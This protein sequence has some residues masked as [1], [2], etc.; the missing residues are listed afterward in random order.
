MKNRLFVFFTAFFFST[1]SLAENV[2]IEAKN[3]TLDKDQEISIFENDVT[4][5]TKDKIIKS[6][7]VRYNKKKGILIIKENI[8]VRDNQ[9]NLIKAEYANYD[10]INKIF[11]TQGP[12]EILTAEKYLIETSDIVL[13]KQNFIKSEKNT[14]I[15]DQDNNKILLGNFD[16]LIKEN[17]F[18]SIGL[19]KVK[20]NNNNSY[21]F[22]QIYIDTK[23]KEILGTDIKA[24]LNDPNFKINKNNEPRVYANTLKIANKDTS[25]DKSIFT[26]CNY[27]ENEK[28]P[29]WTIQASKMLHDNKKKTIY[30]NNA[31]VKVYNI[32]IF[33][34]PR[35]SHPDPT[36]D[37]RSGFLIP[38]VSNTKNLGLGVTIPYFFA[39]DDDKDFTLTNRFYNREN[40]L[41]L[42]EYRQAF[43]NSNLILDLGFT[44]GYKT[45][46]TTKKKGAKSHFFSKFTKNFSNENSDTTIDIKIQN[47]SDDKYLK[48]YKINTDLVEFDKNELESS[49]N[50]SK[51]YENSFL[52]IN[53]S[54][55]E[56]LQSDYDDKYEYI[57]PEVTLDKNLLASNNYGYLDL[58]TNF[59]AHNFDTNKTT[60]FLTNEFN[61]TY[62]N[63]Q[64]DSGINGKILGHFRN[65]NYD[66]KNV[67]KY[68]KNTTNEFFGAIGYLA[69]I[70]FFKKKK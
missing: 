61:W 70:D 69:K 3:I 22:S 55:Y 10:E 12:T 17:I 5:K 65:I 8:S 23:K 59:K 58:T 25:F 15:T 28:C 16:Y 42:G 36:V 50:L 26:Y 44:E 32:P 51:N 52:G 37:R 20:D 53:A 43:K 11:K 46:S 45:N 1:A 63:L 35:L 66:V 54:I 2:S 38:N 6:E 14:T 7:Y 60:K 13:V 30:Y 21:E 56:T 4:V 57:F 64:F 40:P 18:K 67:E 62:D 49:F 41:L 33:F 24:F 27:R 47:V 29:P 31:V 39:V 34:F 19:I 48:L 68:K 9:N